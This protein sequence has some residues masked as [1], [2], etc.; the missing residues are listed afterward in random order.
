MSY[1]VVH[2][3]AAV[4]SC[5]DTITFEVLQEICGQLY[6]RVI[7]QYEEIM[8]EV[9]V[10]RW[11]KIPT[12]VREIYEFVS[13]NSSKYDGILLGTHILRNDARQYALAKFIK[14]PIGQTREIPEAIQCKDTK[15]FITLASQMKA[16]K[17]LA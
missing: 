4:Y 15:C 8:E 6:L 11:D 16:V 5:G 7:V 1:V 3:A 10:F 13:A 14:D 9:F 2:I 12:E 17:N